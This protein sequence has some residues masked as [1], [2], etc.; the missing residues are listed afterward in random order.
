MKK[1]IALL[2]CALLL[3]SLLAG[4]QKPEAPV[5]DREEETEAD[6][7]E[8]AP[9]EEPEEEPEEEPAGLGDEPEEPELPEAD[10][11][12]EEKDSIDIGGLLGALS[13]TDGDLGAIVGVIGEE[14]AGDLMD[15]LEALGVTEYLGKV[16]MLVSGEVIIGSYDQLLL[17]GC[18]S[19]MD[20]ETVLK[21][22]ETTDPFEVAMGGITL[23][24]RVANP[25]EEDIRM[26]SG[27]I[28]SYEHSPEL[29]FPA[30]AI[31]TRESILK[32]FGAPYSSDEDSITY[33]TTAKGLVDW[34]EL[35]EKLG[36]ACFE[37]DFTRT[38]TYVFEDDELVSVIMEAPYYIYDGLAD[39]VDAKELEALEGMTKAEIEEIEEVRASILRELAA[40]FESRAIEAQIDVRTGE[41]TMGDTVLFEDNSAALSA[42]GEAYLDALFEAYASV[43]L[44]A[45]YVDRINYIRIEGH[46]S[47]T[48]TYEYNLDLS[49][50]RAESV[51]NYCL[52]SENNGLSTEQR[53]TLAELLVA[54][55]YS[56]TDPVYDDAG[57]ID[58]EASRRVAIKFFI[59]TSASKR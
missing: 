10:E 28:C 13:E 1:L 21:P 24:V 37:E 2:L 23:M 44:D 3:V 40:A 56:F 26:G 47:P 6:E 48:G 36:L 32:A 38:M 12:E 9:Q 25:T 4:C 46:A 8:K 5:K 45:E 42:E 27:I 58:H 41:I 15:E 53:A 51:M 29:S 33:M 22:E 43:L 14:F 49:Q 39:N 57:E 54:E 50:R 17:L 31:T 7:S 16:S 34:V 55:G 52:E 19:D 11:A 20:P 18:T 35:A 30:S 59:I